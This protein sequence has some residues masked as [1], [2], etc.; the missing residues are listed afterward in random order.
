MAHIKWFTVACAIFCV[1]LAFADNDVTTGMVS[2]GYQVQQPATVVLPEN[3]DAEAASAAIRE[4]R[5]AGDQERVR[6]LAAQLSAWWQ[7]NVAHTY[8]PQE[9]GYNAEPP[10]WNTESHNPQGG[11]PDWGDDVRIAPQDGVRD[12]KIAS[13]SNGDLYS[14]ALWIDGTTDHILMHRSTDDG[15]TWTVYWDNSF[16]TLDISSLGILNDNDTLITWYVLQSGSTYRT[17]VRV[18]L[19][20]TNDTPIYWGSPTGDFNPIIYSNLHI[21]TDAPIY[22][23]GEYVYATWSEQY[24]SGPDST[25][26][27]SAVSYSNDVS[28]W[29]I[30]PTRLR[31]SS[32][33]NIYYTGTRT[34]FGSD[35]DRMW[36]IAWLHPLGYPTTYDRQI[37]GWYS[38]NY[39][40]TWNTTPVDITSA[41]NDIDEYDCAVAASHSNAN[42]VII[43]TEDSLAGVEMDANCWY[44]TDDGTNW[45]HRYWVYSTYDNF[46]GN[47]WVD[48]NSNAFFGTCRS[49][50]G[51]AEQVRYKEGS[52]S[53]PNSWATS[54]VINDN[55]ASLSDV[56]GPSVSYNMGNGDAVIAWNDYNSA[57]YS[58]WFD[59]EDWVT[60]VAELPVNEIT[61]LNLRLAPNPAIAF[62]KLTYSISTEGMVNIVMY[63]ATGR[64]VKDLVNETK[65]AGEYSVNIDNTDLAAGIYFV[66]VE[67]PDGA[68]TKTMTI[69]R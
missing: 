24:G 54:V 44:S 18:V 2:E 21:T 32:G 17:W 35:S 66:K 55:T 48:D 1:G 52:I 9:R 43:C 28:A 56:Y 65:A 45:T 49:N 39:G 69:V 40:S 4:A 3:F 58:I 13:I 60:G 64:L 51:T 41:T 36:I 11:S 67:T 31:A 47:V 57:I 53:D 19:P 5:Q 16:G 25:R 20:G 14:Y 62:A 42:W 68:S 59:S 38:D 26:V 7:N 63:D 30:G 12:V 6:E 8:S 33:A 29:E 23:T 22:T 61:R 10:V 50:T 46:L 37:R 27:M 15:Q 34:A